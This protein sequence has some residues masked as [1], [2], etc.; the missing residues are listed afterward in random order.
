MDC[1]DRLEG[2]FREQGVVFEVKEHPTAYTAQRIAATEHVPGRAFA[3]VVIARSDGELVMLVLPASSMVDVAKVAGA[4]HGEQVG[5]ASEEEFAPTFPD[6]E[7][8]AM[9]P[10]GNLYGL[11]VYVDPAMGKSDHVVF[12]AGTHGVTMS[13][14]YEDFERLAQPT[15]A[16]ITVTR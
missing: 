3:K 7:P 6:C 4:I 1:R 12:Q 15:V 5:L 11:P 14:A 9:P 8:G 2:Y 10:F 13:V 16:D